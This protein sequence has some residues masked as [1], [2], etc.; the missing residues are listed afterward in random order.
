MF[1]TVTI[2]WDGAFTI[3]RRE[4]ISGMPGKVMPCA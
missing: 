2:H 1:M 4:R 3:A